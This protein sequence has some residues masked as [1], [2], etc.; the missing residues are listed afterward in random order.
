LYLPS[1]ALFFEEHPIMRVSL[2]TLAAFAI[3]SFCEGLAHGQILSPHGEA[4]ISGL[5]SVPGGFNQTVDGDTTFLQDSAQTNYDSGIQTASAISHTVPNYSQFLGGQ[6]SSTQTQGGG[7]GP[8][9]GADAN[10]SGIWRDVLFL[11]GPGPLPSA[12]T[13]HFT[14]EGV[15][16]GSSAFQDSFLARVDPPST[17]DF[18]RSGGTLNIINFGKTQDILGFDSFTAG[19]FG[20]FTATFSYRAMYD[21]TLGGYGFNV[22]ESA[23]AVAYSNAS[24]FVEWND[25]LT[26]SFVTNADGT[27]LSGFNLSFDSGLILPSAVPEPS[28]W[29]LA[30]TGSAIGLVVAA[31]R[32]RKERRQQRPVGPL[33]EIQ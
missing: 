25:P 3:L 9:A 10:A 24:A 4:S 15:M 5:T 21:P 32:K 19:P 7:G 30:G 31:F 26:A 22:I 13:F 8:N 23:Q 17:A 20:G 12:V 6:A 18:V 33:E 14:V 16:T 11:N 2:I 27:P 29:I 1:D 28:T